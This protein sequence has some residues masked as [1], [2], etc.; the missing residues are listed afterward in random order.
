[1]SDI[2]HNNPATLPLRPRSKR[3]PWIAV[4]VVIVAIAIAVTLFAVGDT[5]S[6][7]PTAATPAAV[8]SR[9]ADV[10]YDG[11]PE[12]GT[13]GPAASASGSTTRYDGGPEEGT[14]GPA[15]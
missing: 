14:R 8:P 13:T 15:H 6:S 12:E 7:S 4:A 5:D 2:A 11:G 3:L 1:M 10:R 9:P